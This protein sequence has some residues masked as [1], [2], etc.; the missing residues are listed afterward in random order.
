M[1]A[2]GLRP[3]R[4]CAAAVI[5]ALCA[6]HASG[7]PIGVIPPAPPE[8]GSPST[9]LLSNATPTPVVDLGVIAS[10]IVVS[11]ADP[12]VWNVAVVTNLTHSRSS[13]LSVT[14]TSPAGTVVTLTSGN[15][16]AN[17]DVFNG[18]VWDDQA[19]PGG[20]VPYTSNDGLV[21][22]HAYV[23]GVTATPLAPE[24]ALGAFVGENPNGTWTLRVAD[25]AA[26]H[27]GALSGWSLSIST[28]VSAPRVYAQLSPSTSNAVAILDNATAASTITVPAGI[29]TRICGLTV[30]TNITHSNSADLDMTLTSPAGTVITL[31]TDNGGSMDNVFD[32][33]LWSDR[34]N[35][36][37]QIPYTENDGL[38]TDCAYTNGV[39][40]SALV[41]E[42]ALSALRGQSPSGDWTLRIRDDNAGGTGTLSG[43]MLN[44][45][46]CSC[47]TSFAASPL[48]VDEHLGQT[49]SNLNGVLEAGEL[50]EVETSWTNS[51]G[52]PFTLVTW[53]GNFGGPAGPT[54]SLIDAGAAYGTIAPQSTSNCW[55]T[56]GD[57]YRVQV[58][59][60]RPATHWDAT[61][62]E[63]T[64]P[65]ALGESQDPYGKTWT[66]HVGGSFA[67]VPSSN[68]YYRAI[69]TLLHNKVTAGGPCGGYCPQAAVPRKQMAAFL[70]KSRDGASYVP[71]PATGVFA[72]VSPADPFA[73]WIEELYRRGIA[74]GCAT[75]PLRYCPDSSVTRQQMAVFLLKTLLG[76]TYVPP[77]PIGIFNDVAVDSP[78][79]PWI[80]D[81]T[82]RGIAAGCGGPYFCPKAPS[83]RAQMAV[84]LTNTFGLKLY[85]P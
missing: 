62:D 70:L 27:T 77:A 8:C 13:D 61:F 66:L 21:T 28:L 36:D 63:L 83:T 38:A 81:L 19:D 65:L 3:G 42:E 46:T 34:A 6:G 10:P 22:D 26:G 44:V 71:P 50:V 12:Y 57:C 58:T 45:T 23:N 41:P 80:E 82:Q 35:L 32:G 33:T 59:G 5:V 67:D 17:A 39:A 4:A 76:S 74:A 73:P 20:Q 51:G 64:A 14:L 7:Q 9:L 48:R 31:T 37:G 25:G 60:A 68:I 54:Y 1:K 16:G 79:R 24:E 72:D 49:I 55:D 84:F 75:A 78:F 85:G 30:Q 52:T 40:E 43:W 2:G 47:A 11:G 15:G 69:E 29:G 56:T 18:T 53:A